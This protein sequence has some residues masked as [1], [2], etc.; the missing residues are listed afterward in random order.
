MEGHAEKEDVP[1]VCIGYSYNIKKI[2]VFLSAKGAGST[3]LGE[4]YLAKFPHKFGNVCKTELVWPDIMSNYFNKSN[5][6]NLHNQ[7]QQVKVV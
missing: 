6:L 5:M 2:L 4:L 3:Q 1:L 7:A